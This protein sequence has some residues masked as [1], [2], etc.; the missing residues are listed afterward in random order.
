VAGRLRF[1]RNLG[2]IVMDVDDTER[3]DLRPLGG[4]DAAVINDLTGTDVTKVDIDLAAAIGGGT[5]DGAADTITVNGT[6][7]PDNIAVAANSGV[8]DVTGLFTAIAIS[9]SEVAND[10]LAINTRGG[11]DDVVIGPGVEEL[12]QTLVDLG[13]DN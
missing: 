2:N 4:R 7:D 5:G 3:V 1:T 9:H 6:D 8:V 11:D 10:L 13:G 12:I